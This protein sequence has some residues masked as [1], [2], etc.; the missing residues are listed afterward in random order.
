VGDGGLTWMFQARSDRLTRCALS[1]KVTKQ[2]RGHVFKHVIA[3]S[4]GEF[5]GGAESPFVSS[6]LKAL[7][8]LLGRGGS[9]S[10][11]RRHVFCACWFLKR[12]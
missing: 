5:R 2:P 9:C 4:W 7:V 6:F 1:G 11:R 12:M 8:P 3:K 10:E